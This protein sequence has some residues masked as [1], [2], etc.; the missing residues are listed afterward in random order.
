MNRL[1]NDFKPPDV[2]YYASESDDEH[3]RILMEEVYDEKMMG[4]EEIT[5]DPELLVGFIDPEDKG[6]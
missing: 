4:A 1:L 6:V 2:N 3:A 5:F